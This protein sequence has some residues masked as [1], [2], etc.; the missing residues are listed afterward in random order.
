LALPR[1]AAHPEK[2]AAAG[3]GA[4]GGD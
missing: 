4:D 2:L 1:T 3:V